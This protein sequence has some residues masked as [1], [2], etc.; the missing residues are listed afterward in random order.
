MTSMK[1]DITMMSLNVGHSICH[2]FM[3]H[4]DKF[5]FYFL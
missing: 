2:T 1:G 4:Q 5:L 3:F